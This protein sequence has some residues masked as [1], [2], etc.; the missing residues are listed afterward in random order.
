[1]FCLMMIDEVIAALCHS[2]T[3]WDLWSWSQGESAQFLATNSL[4][5][6]WAIALN[7]ALTLVWATMGCLL[8]L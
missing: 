1:M 3:S 4:Q 2:T 8:L 6:P 7:L 5:M